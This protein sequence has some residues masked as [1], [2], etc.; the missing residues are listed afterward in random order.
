MNLRHAAAFA[1]VGSYLIVQ[2]GN[3]SSAS[4]QARQQTIKSL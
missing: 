1:L 2:S 4:T 3:A